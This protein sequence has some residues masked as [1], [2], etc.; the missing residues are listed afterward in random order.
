MNCQIIILAVLLGTAFLSSCNR[1]NISTSH[2]DSTRVVV[3]DSIIPI[4]GTI[5]RE[6]INIDSLLKLVKAGIKPGVITKP[7]IISD[8]SMNAQLRLI[9][10]QYGNITAECEK[11]DEFIRTQNK[12]IDRLK[13]DKQVQKVIVRKMPVWGLGIIGLLV[14]IILLLL[15]CL[16]L[17]IFRGITRV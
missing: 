5:I 6:T 17:I 8:T 2:I 9:I 4:P 7:I 1:K 12:E 14:L 3:H 16:L 13:E 11:K 15:A 10:D